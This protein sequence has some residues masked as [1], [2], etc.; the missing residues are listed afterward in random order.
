MSTSEPLTALQMAVLEFERHWWKYPGAK[1]SAVRDWFGL[2]PARYSQ[3][4]VTLLDLPAAEVYDPELVR[5]LR[6][7]RD[8]RAAARTRPDRRAAL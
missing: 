6:R 4:L 8:Q 2:A 1:D 3:V 5:R 7:L